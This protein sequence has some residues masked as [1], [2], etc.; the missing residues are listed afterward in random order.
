MKI[1]IWEGEKWPYNIKLCKNERI[2][3]YILRSCLIASALDTV[4]TNCSILNLSNLIAHTNIVLWARREHRPRIVVVGLQTVRCQ[5]L[6]PWHANI[7]LCAKRGMRE[8]QGTFCWSMR[9]YGSTARD[10][11]RVVDE[12]TLSGM[13]GVTKGEHYIGIPT[14]WAI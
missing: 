3:S 4:L 2:I 6:Y 10:V 1:K 5:S 14:V 8:G 9:E 7:P 12:S 13:R 11:T